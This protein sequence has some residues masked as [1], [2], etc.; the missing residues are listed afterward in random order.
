MT[1]RIDET[2]AERGTRYGDFRV[3]AAETQKI[4]DLFRA[5]P[6]WEALPPYMREALDAAALKIGRIVAG[7]FMHLDNWHDLVGYARLAEDLLRADIE[8][9]VKGPALRDPAHLP[10]E[11][12]VARALGELHDLGFHIDGDEIVNEH[13]ETP[14]KVLIDYIPEEHRVRDPDFLKDPLRAFLASRNQDSSK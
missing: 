14:V 11:E 13:E 1:S 6:N 5:S 2:L 4:R 10:F 3:L 7:D 8:A 12:R 9:G